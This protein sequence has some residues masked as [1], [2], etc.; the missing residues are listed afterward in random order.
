MPE[1]SQ[2]TTKQGD[3]GVTRALSGDRYS[4]SHPIM[5]CVGELDELRS[6]LALLRQMLVAETSWQQECG[7][8]RWL[9]HACFALGAVCSDPLNQ[10]PQYRPCRVD[11]TLLARLEQ[12]QMRLEAETPLPRAFIAGAATLPAAQA[13]IACTVARRF[14]RSLVRLKEAVPEFEAAV[15]LAFANRLSDFLF[16]LARHL[17]QETHEIVD[18]TILNQDEA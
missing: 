6:H 12:E 16:I 1:R 5:E 9:I 8:L 11:T 18:Y 14:E 13:D 15:L 10:K 7:F 2:V 4:K 17:E 3:G